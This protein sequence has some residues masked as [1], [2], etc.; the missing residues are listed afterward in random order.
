VVV[1]VP[2][3]ALHVRGVVGNLRARGKR[4][5]QHLV[6]R[7]TRLALV[8][9]LAVLGTHA[10]RTV[11]HLHAR[12]QQAQQLAQLGQALLEVQTPGHL[13]LHAEAQAVHAVRVVH[14]P[15]G[16][17]VLEGLAVLAVV[18]DLHE[19]VRAAAQRVLDHRHGRGLRLGT[20]EEAAVLALRLGLLEARHAA[21]LAVHEH[22]GVARDGH[23]RQHDAR[24]ELLRKRHEAR[25][26]ARQVLGH[27]VLAPHQI[28]ARSHLRLAHV[29]RDH[30]L[31][32]L[33]LH[34]AREQLA[35]ELALHLRHLLLNARHVH[36]LR[37]R[38]AHA[39]VLLQQRA[40]AHVT[41]R[42][43]HLGQLA[44][45]QP[46]VQQRRVARLLEEAAEGVAAVL[47]LHHLL[48]GRLRVKR[49][50]QL[51]E[52]LLRRPELLLLGRLVHLGR[53]RVE[54]WRLRRHATGQELSQLGQARTLLRRLVLHARQHAQAV[55]VHA[56]RVEDRREGQVVGE[57]RAIH[58]VV[59]HLHRQL[60]GLAQS[61]HHLGHDPRLR[62][63]ALEEAAVAALRL[64]L[65]VARHALEAR[66]A[67]LH[68]H[69]GDRHVRHRHGQGQVRHG[70]L[71]RAEPRAVARRWHRAAFARRAQ[72][73]EDAHRRRGHLGGDGGRAARAAATAR[74]RPRSRLLNLASAVVH[75]AALDGL[76]H[77]VVVV[78]VPLLALHVRGVVGNL[79]ARGKRVR[80]HLVLRATRLALVG[81]LAVLGTHAGRTV[82]HLHARR[83]Q[84]QQLAQLGQAL[85]EV[86]TPGHLELHAEAQAVHAVR[87][88][89][90]P[91]GQE[92]LEGLA[93]LA[94]VCDLHEAV[95]AA[96]QR[97]LDHRHGR[98]L[99]LGTLEEAAVLALRL[100]L[101][102]ARHA[103]ELAVHEHH[104]V[105][106]DGHLRQHDARRELL[107][108]RHEARH[109]ARQVLGHLVLAPHQ[110]LARSHLRLAH[111]SRDHRLALLR[112]HEARE[113]LA[114]E[115]ALHLR[116]LLL[117]ARHVHRLRSRRAHA[118]V[119]L[120]QRA[121]AHV[122]RRAAHLGQLARAQPEVQQ[123]RVARLLEEAAEGVA[124]VLRLHHLLEGRLRV[125]RPLQLGEGLLSR[126][127]LPLF[128]GVVHLDG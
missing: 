7:A 17:E 105:A 118:Q 31:A 42:A 32:L 68:R 46:E 115:L 55:A 28:L 20:L 48:E 114:S 110:I 77:L 111:V 99:R 58:A 24:R 66:V 52:E 54:G 30:R 35:S 93:V 101:L 95:R 72:L 18:C 83:Q 37:S 100:G 43:A 11:A 44:R 27:L 81:H 123:R 79:R 39:Q 4:V 70:L 22:H 121:L 57:G 106:R 71:E 75:V 9:H 45:A 107:R 92:V 63:C 51:G 10:G 65:G 21:E 82:A 124:A 96:A 91:H 64:R 47:R 50:L 98:G 109:E 76:E 84:A 87:V 13:E 36:R 12:R 59:G 122:T 108:K 128:R 2:L 8:G 85:L 103:A 29:S 19:A 94:V 16:Q 53:T 5:R 49:P 125:K 14:R 1:R 78:R 56:V 116:H 62:L 33:R 60:L 88:V 3:L 117:N 6:L 67:P 126:T 113:Q 15:H 90:R 38:R 69:A 34:E 61:A 40:L 120:Q 86:Q 25:H 104:G 80:Q 102:E 89:H 41:R 74:G 127:E 112:L 23:L 97:V 73:L 119:L 26:E